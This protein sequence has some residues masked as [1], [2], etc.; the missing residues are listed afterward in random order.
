[1]GTTRI[2]CVCIAGMWSLP[3]TTLNE[4]V[5]ALGSKLISISYKRWCYHMAALR[6]SRLEIYLFEVH[7]QHF[8]FEY[9]GVWTIATQKF[10]N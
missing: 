10:E 7:R 1:M 3:F 4:F 8:V 2:S 6:Y 5:V 9:L